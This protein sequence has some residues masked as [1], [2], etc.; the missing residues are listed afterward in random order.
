MRHSTVRVPDP[1]RCSVAQSLLSSHPAVLE[2]GSRASRH[3]LTGARKKREGRRHGGNRKARLPLR[4]ERLQTWFTC[5]QTHPFTVQFRGFSMFVQWC[6]R[7]QPPSFQHLSRSEGKGPPREPLPPTACSALGRRQCA[8]CLE[9]LATPDVP[10]GLRS[11][12]LASWAGTRCPGSLV[13]WCVSALYCSRRRNGM[14]CVDTPRSVGCQW[15]GVEVVST[16][17]AVNVQAQVFLWT[18]FCFPEVPVDLLG[19]VVTLCLAF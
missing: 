15:T 3:V 14:R 4:S 8:L 5:R 18:R 13:S 2:G 16:G 1:C 10:C 19:R 6:E 12:C 17:A 9:R 11:L 7:Q